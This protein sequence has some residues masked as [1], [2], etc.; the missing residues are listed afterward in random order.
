MNIEAYYQQKRDRQ[1]KALRQRQKKAFETKPELAKIHAEI[2]RLKMQTA[3]HPDETAEKKLKGLMIQ[4]SVYLSL[5]DMPENYLELWHDCEQCKDTGLLPDGSTCSCY[6]T[7]RLELSGINKISFDDWDLTAIPEENEQREISR[8]LQAFCKGFAD[9]YPDNPRRNILL[10][11]NTG[12]GKTFALTCIGFSIAARG[13]SVKMLTASD[14]FRIVMDKV[15]GERD[16]NALAALE[17]TPVL[18]FD[19]LGAEP[20]ANGILSDYVYYLIDKRIHAGR[21]TLMTT[22]LTTDELIARYGDRLC[23]RITNPRTTFAIKIAG[24]DLRLN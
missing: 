5:N 7:A 22:N 10:M 13:V 6:N 12:V 3:V 11:G 20:T 19:D 2:K 21:H 1:L 9:R 23:S 4:Q 14:F 16:I 15:I 24:K 8:K 18:I 17:N